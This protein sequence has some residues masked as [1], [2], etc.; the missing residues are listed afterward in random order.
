MVG[1]APDGGG[2]AVPRPRCT[3]RLLPGTGSPTTTAIAS[4][5]GRP[6]L[7]TYKAGTVPSPTPVCAGCA[8][9]RHG[10]PS[11]PFRAF[12]APTRAF[13]AP[14]LRKRNILLPM[15]RGN[16]PRETCFVHERSNVCPSA[17]HPMRCK[18]LMCQQVCDWG[19]TTETATANGQRGGSAPLK[20][21]SLARPGLSERSLPRFFLAGRHRVPKGRAGV[22][23]GRPA[24][25]PSQSSRSRRALPRITVLRSTG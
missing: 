12:I 8:G 23:R 13:L 16:R 14:W 11:L 3:R 10:S 2:G 21:P 1:P 20:W 5:A 6:P 7:A 22:R 9:I 18:C 15:F 25:M 17:K 24:S 4:A 19:G